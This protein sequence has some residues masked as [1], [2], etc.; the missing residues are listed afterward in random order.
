MTTAQRPGEPVLRLERVGV[1]LGGRPIVRDVSLDV[2]PGQVVA[3]LGANGSG[4]STLLKAL[5][6]LN[7]VT[8]GSV[9]MFGTPLPRFRDWSRVGYVPQR[10]TVGAGVP[11]TVREVVAGGRIARRRPFWPMTRADRRTVAAALESVGLADR[12][13]HSVATLSGG[14]QQ[15]A[16]VARTLA[17]E[18]E[19]LLLDEP[20]AG[21]DHDS[22]EAIAA[23]LGE[24]ARAGASVV[25]VLHELGP[26][27]P[28]IDRAVALREGRVTYD[29]PP[30]QLALGDGYGHH[31]PVDGPLPAWQAP[32]EVRPEAGGR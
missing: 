28:L 11:A 16:L 15:R 19:L 21:V 3:V 27:A 9:F 23:T 24:R 2:A 30:D 7:P 29:G 8:D 10:S 17:G 1:A 31:H 20:N 18:P 32:L 26:F 5:V 12:A 14:Q 4:K 22:Q 13:G 25:V 6:G